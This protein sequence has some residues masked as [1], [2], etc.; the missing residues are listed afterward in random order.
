[1]DL[2]YVESGSTLLGAWTDS[3]WK[4]DIRLVVRDWVAKLGLVSAG[5][6]ITI[7]PGVAV[8]ALPPGIAVVRIDHVAAVR[9]TAVVQRADD[10]AVRR[11]Q[12]FVELLRDTAAE[13]SAGVRRTVRRGATAESTLYEP[14][15]SHA[16]IEGQGSQSY[17]VRIRVV[18]TGTSA[19]N[20]EKTPE[21]VLSGTPFQVT[22]TDRTEIN[23]P[24]NRSREPGS[25]W[26]RVAEPT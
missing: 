19:V 2:C 7:V 12:K 3:S 9:T 6:G 20:D 13:L 10:L 14:N 15:R 8:P 26:E 21:F 22:A 5:V 11:Q 16:I 24:G 18:S 4:P 23:R 25:A 1:M 17:R